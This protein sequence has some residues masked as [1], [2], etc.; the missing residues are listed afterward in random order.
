MSVMASH[1]ASVTD[2]GVSASRRRGL[3]AW[4][5]SEIVPSF[6]ER[7]VEQALPAVAL[8]KIGGEEVDAVLG[9][10][11]DDVAAQHG[12]AFFLQGLGDAAADAAGAAG[13]QGAF[14]LQKLRAH[15]RRSLPSIGVSPWTGRGR[16]WTS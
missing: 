3:A 10:R 5:N 15:A 13:D 14:A 9:R 8:G 2:S 4:T 11:G 16:P 6:C 1:V 7:A 12:G